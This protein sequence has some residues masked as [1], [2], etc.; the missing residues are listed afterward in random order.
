MHYRESSRHPR[1]KKNS[2]RTL[3]TLPL[4]ERDRRPFAHAFK[5]YC[6]TLTVR[7]WIS[8]VWLVKNR[9]ALCCDALTE[10]R[11]LTTASATSIS[12]CCVPEIQNIRG[13]R[14]NLTQVACCA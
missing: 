9:I 12:A 3:S 14:L 7:R 6:A 13:M 11:I 2:A 5:V 1:Y 8:P 10:T 4:P